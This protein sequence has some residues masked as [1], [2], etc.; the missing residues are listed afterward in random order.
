MG[1]EGF[2]RDLD[3]RGAWI[4]LAVA[5]G[6]WIGLAAVVVP[7]EWSPSRLDPV[8]ADGYFTPSEI[9]RAEAY[10]GSVRRWGDAALLLGLAVAL[11]LGLT[12]WGR[13]ASR[14]FTRH[15][16]WV[17]V[18][19]LV[20]AFELAV[21][22]VRL[23]SAWQIRLLR[24]QEGLTTQSAAGW[25]ADQGLS[26]AVSW[27]VTTLVVLLVIGCARRWP[28]RWYLPASALV[29]AATYVVSLAYPVVVEPLFNRFT[30]LRD[31]ALRTELVT[32]AEEQGVDVGEVLVADASR[33]TTTLNAYVSGLGGTKRLVLYDTLVADA[34]DDEVVAVAAHE[35]AHAARRD[36]LAGTTL[37]AVGGVIGIA[38][39]AL[40]LDGRRG[41]RRTGGLAQVTSVWPLLATAAAASLLVSPV[42]NTVSRAIEARADIDALATTGDDAG[43]RDLHVRLAQRSLADPTPPGWRQLWWGSH[44]TVLQRLALTDPAA[45]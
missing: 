31:G 20:L 22:A 26:L 3:G 15:R 44:P 30:P 37:G 39:L 27:A 18:P 36:V 16:W 11:V 23:P 21:R 8:P 4:L 7:W 25:W 19:L 33:R 32:M 24:L 45:R 10:T 13:T 17:A 28:R 1:V 6:A 2:R 9:A 42:Q 5:L 41:R 14:P 38:A 12:R 35:V 29:V 34:T 43:F 40:L